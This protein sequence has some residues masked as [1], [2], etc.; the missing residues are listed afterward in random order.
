VKNAITRGRINNS[1]TA[2]VKLAFWAVVYRVY[3][4]GKR[5]T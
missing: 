3:K 1:K 5:Q 4:K 2:F